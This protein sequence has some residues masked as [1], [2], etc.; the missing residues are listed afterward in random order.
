MATVLWFSKSSV[1]LGL[2]FFLYIW[3]LAKGLIERGH[4]GQMGPNHA[5]TRWAHVVHPIL[6]LVG[7][8]VSVLCIE[9]SSMNTS[10]VFFLNI[11]SMF[12]PQRR[13]KE[14]FC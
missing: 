7:P 11:F 4:E 10:V 6:R 12:P 1:L 3:R 8:L 9:S 13:Q 5:A 14:V 2:G